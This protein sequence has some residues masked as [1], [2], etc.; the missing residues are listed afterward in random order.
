MQVCKDPNLDDWQLFL[1]D[2]G[3][4]TPRERERASQNPRIRVITQ[5]HFQELLQES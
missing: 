3:Y 4:N 5:Q 2:W 1:V